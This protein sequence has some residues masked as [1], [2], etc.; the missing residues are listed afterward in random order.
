MSQYRI[1]LKELAKELGVSTSTV[2]RALNNNPALPEETIVRIK[3]FAKQKKYRPNLRA[4]ALQSSRSGIIAMI[5]PDINMFFVPEL[6]YGVN[7]AAK[8]KGYSVMIFQSENQL[9][10]EIQWLTYA[11]NLPV[12]GILLSLSEESNH[13]EHLADADDFGIPLVLVDKVTE[14][15]SYHQVTIDDTNAAFQAVDYLLENGHRNIVGLFGNEALTM[16][17]KR[18]EGFRLACIEKGFT[19][20]E[21]CLISV[22]QIL[23]LDEILTEQLQVFPETTALFCMS[24]ELLINVHYWLQKQGKQIPDDISLIAI[25]D[26]FLPYTLFP[27]VAHIHH[28]GF[29]VGVKS[30]NMLHELIKNPHSTPTVKTMKTKL[31]V[32]DSVKRCI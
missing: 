13:T 17:Q 6:I 3:E 8:E 28:S 1:T 14:D 32:M 19:P 30:M 27:N 12:D 25:S 20:D 2:S 16:T 23:E 15:S 18:K 21:R 22:D 29:E 24:D 4:K 26:G 7:T 10:R 5:V 11:I 31:Y 9:E